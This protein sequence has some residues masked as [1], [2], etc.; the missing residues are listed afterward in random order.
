MAALGALDA[1]DVPPARRTLFFRADRAHPHLHRLS[2]RL[3]GQ[4]MRDLVVLVGRERP[5][6]D[7]F[8]ALEACRRE[9]LGFA[10]DVTAADAARL[11][12]APT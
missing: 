8:S 10:V 11:G 7:A 1:A 12:E 4:S 6:D 2:V 3:S 9:Q 5:A